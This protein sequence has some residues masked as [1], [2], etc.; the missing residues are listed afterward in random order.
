MHHLVEPSNSPTFYAAAS[1]MISSPTAC[2]STVHYFATAMFTTAP[3]TA[4]NTAAFNTDTPTAANYQTL[5]RLSIIAYPTTSN[6]T[7][8]ATTL[9]EATTIPVCPSP[10]TFDSTITTS[11]I[12]VFYLAAVTVMAAADTVTLHRDNFSSCLLFPCYSFST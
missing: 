11:L 7:T 2:P 3:P 12:A 10:D 1:P 6:A 5:T 4:I 9:D 8:A